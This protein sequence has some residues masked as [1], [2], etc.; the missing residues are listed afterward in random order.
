MN[1]TFIA[2][3]ALTFALALA[4]TSAIASEWAGTMSCGELQNAPNAKSKDPFRGNVT[5]RII[6]QHAVLERPWRT[7]TES[8]EGDVSKGRPLQLAGLGYFFNNKDGAWKTRATL[9]QRGQ[10]YDGVAVLES[11][12][13]SR[14]FRDCTITLTTVSYTHLTLPTKRIV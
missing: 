9:T 1:F 12:D 10:Q 14:K 7:G 13:G 2:R 3:P 6:G 4:A 11:P 8:L 5:L